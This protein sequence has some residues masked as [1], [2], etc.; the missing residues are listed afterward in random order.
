ML[1]T[2]MSS[3]I[4]E[5]LNNVHPVQNTSFSVCAQDI[6][7]A[8]SKGTVE[9]PWIIFTHPLKSMIFFKTLPFQ[10]LWDTHFT[11]PMD[12]G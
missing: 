3:Y 1:K 10:E 8:N 2:L 11:L 7:G 12:I 4:S 6:L 9:I 5:L